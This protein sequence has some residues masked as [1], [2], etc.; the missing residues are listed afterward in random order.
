VFESLGLQPDAAVL[1]RAILDNPQYGVN[2]LG[3]LLGWL[4][5]RVRSTLD[6][7]A[8]LSLVRPSWEQPETLLAV[9][10]AVGFSIL[11]AQQEQE[12]LRRQQELAANR[13]AV[14]ELIEEHSWY[15]HARY[16]GIEHL[17]GLD[18]IRSRIEELAASCETELMAFVPRGAQSKEAMEASRPLDLAML[19]RGVLVRTV[20]LQSIHNDVLTLD[21]AHW[22]ADAGALVRT[23]GA[24]S[25]RLIIY[26]RQAALVPVDPDDEAAGALLS[27]GTGIV[28]ALC[29]HFEGVWA[30]A[31]DLNHQPRRRGE[32]L[33]DQQLAV[34]QLLADGHT[35]ETIARRLGV[36]LRTTRRI[37]AELMRFLGARSRFQAGVRA[38][39]RGLLGPGDGG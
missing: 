24:L 20:Y 3:N 21:Y 27:H 23:F 4:T 39:E 37:T 34:L 19:Q 9:S 11:L 33:T 28:N 26:D 1:Y 18:E 32:E 10:P 14:M 13:R 30:K 25:Q 36:S 29:E 22:L 38:S 31:T 17:T 5:D 12:L 35:D 16:A 15:R 2:D 6:E 7:L 8:E